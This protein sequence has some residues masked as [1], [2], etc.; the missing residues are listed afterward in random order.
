MPRR[1][2]IGELSSFDSQ[3]ERSRTEEFGE[4]GVEKDLEMQ[5]LGGSRE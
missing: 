5:E 1:K 4:G 2:R 3:A